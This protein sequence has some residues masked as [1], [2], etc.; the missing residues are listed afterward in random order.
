MNNIVC[1][2]FRI[3]HVNLNPWNFDFRENG[4]FVLCNLIQNYCSLNIT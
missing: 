4:T 3:L 2:D 1:Y